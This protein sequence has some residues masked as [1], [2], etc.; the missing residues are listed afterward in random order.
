MDNTNKE[1]KEKMSANQYNTNIDILDCSKVTYHLSIITKSTKLK[2][3]NEPTNTNK[4]FLQ[5][6]KY[7]CAFINV[8]NKIV[9]Q[10]TILDE[11]DN[12][13]MLLIRRSVVKI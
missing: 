11:N 3:F 5:R 1:N 10:K 7:K 4:T 8:I 2:H 9:F 12:T 13:V 6:Q